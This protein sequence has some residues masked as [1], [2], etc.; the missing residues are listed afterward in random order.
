M[1]KTFIQKTSLVSMAIVMFTLSYLPSVQASYT[2]NPNGVYYE[3]SR[4]LYNVKG[5]GSYSSIESALNS[6]LDKIYRGNL[7]IPCYQLTGG[8]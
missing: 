2:E 3:L 1:G 6:K 4:L 5:D 7:I 8:H